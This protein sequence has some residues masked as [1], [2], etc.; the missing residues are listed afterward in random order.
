VDKPA[1]GKAYG[2]P[3]DN[4]FAAGGGAPEIYA[5]GLRNPYRWAFDPIT[6]DQWVADVGERLFEEVNLIHK[7][8]NYGW[9]IAEGFDDMT[10]AFTGP[11]FTYGRQFGL[12]IIGGYVFRGNDTSPYYGYFI[13]GDYG[14]RNMW[15]VRASPDPSRVDTVG[16][17]LAPPEPRG[18]GTDLAGNLYIMSGTASIFRLSG[19][20]WDA[21]PAGLMPREGHLKRSYGRILSGHAGGRL[22]TGTAGEASGFARLSIHAMDGRRLGTVDPVGR[23]PEH[24]R[25]GMYLLRRAAP[26]RSH[27]LLVR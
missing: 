18:F 8:A 25:A 20:Q 3:T 17:A 13:F 1:E 24:L 10:E 23:L 14:S 15:G 26:A 27:L 16:L 2:I 5:W 22:E 6:G 12:S 9:D 11:V 19:D 4:P 21:R 7:G